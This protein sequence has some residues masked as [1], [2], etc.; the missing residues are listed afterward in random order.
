MEELAARTYV[1]KLYR[2]NNKRRRVVEQLERAIAASGGRVVSNSFWSQRVAPVFIAAEDSDGHRYGMLVYPFTATYRD[3]TGRPGAEHRFQV[4]F[5][6]P[7]VHRAEPNPLGR[8]PHGVDVTLVLAADPE[9]GLI[10]GLDPFVYGELPIGVSGYYRDDHARLSLD[11]GWHAWVKEKRQPRGRSTVEW[12]GLE[13]MVGIRPN[14][15]LDYVRFEATATSLGLDTA[16]R[17]TLAESWTAGV[18]DR[19]ALEQLFGIDAGTILD[20]VESNFRLGVAVRGSVAE[21]HLQRLLSIAPEVERVVPIDADGRPDLEVLM[22]DGAKLLVE[23]KN[24]LR[25]TYKTGDAKV[26]VQ[27][28]RD[29]ASGR[30]YPFTAFDV[31]AAC[32]FSVTGRWEFRFKK[33]SELTPWA[34]DPTRIAP[35]QRIDNT[36]ASSLSAAV[37]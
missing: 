6:D 24:A 26:E 36:W 9:L 12:D 19:H 29:S 34:P 35:I 20:I 14:R 28:T 16:F 23:C 30:K 3:T 11:R 1:P 18:T 8:D 17:R 2:I 7:V 5:G 31:V 15:F 21:H 27:K 33:A 4:R 10:V 32:M 25:E 22:R 13:A 37:R